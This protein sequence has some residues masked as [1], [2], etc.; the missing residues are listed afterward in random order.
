MAQQAEK[1]E[2]ENLEEVKSE[3][4]GNILSEIRSIVPKDFTEKENKSGV[5]W[6]GPSRT[7]LLKVI[8]TKKGLRIEFNV[9]VDSK[10]TGMICYTKDEAKAKHMGTCQWVY[11][12]SDVD[13]VKA[14]VS[15]AIKGF[16]PKKRADSK[17]EKDKEEMKGKSS[18]D[19]K[20]VANEKLPEKEL[21]KLKGKTTG[22]SKT[23]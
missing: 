15:Q 23:K 3:L 16:E 14:L 6:F 20:Q 12:G 1:V 17:E 21:E 9:E 8:E 13:T 10:V 4:F 22:A 11:S 7:R 18:K 5:T 2:K 19:N